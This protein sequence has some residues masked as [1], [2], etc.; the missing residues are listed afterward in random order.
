VASSLELA[1]LSLAFGAGVAWHLG[2]LTDTAVLL[3]CLYVEITGDGGKGER[4]RSYS[5]AL[6]GDYGRRRQR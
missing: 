2:Y 4:R 3:T 6:R 5:L 1:L